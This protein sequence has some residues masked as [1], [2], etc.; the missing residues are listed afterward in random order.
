MN[1]LAQPFRKEKVHDSIIVNMDQ[2]LTSHQKNGNAS[3]WPIVLLDSL[4]LSSVSKYNISSLLTAGRD[5]F[6][7]IAEFNFMPIR[8]RMRGYE[9]DHFG[10]AINGISLDNMDNRIWPYGLYGGLNEVMRNKDISIGLRNN[11]FSFGKLGNMA[12]IDASA[13]KQRKQTQFGYAFS[14][15]NY[16]HKFSYTKGFG[17]NKSGWAFALSGSHRWANEGYIPGTNYNGWS[18]YIAIDKRIKQQHLFSFVFFGALTKNARQGAATVE[19]ISLAGNNYYNPNWGYWQ[20]QKRNANIANA[21]QPV[22]ILTHEFSIHNTS[23]LQTALSYRVGNKSYS[24]LDWFNVT[25]PRP[26]YYKKLPSYNRR[27]SVLYSSLMQQWRNDER[28]RQIDWNTLYSVNNSFNETFNN[29]KGYRS[30]YILSAAV[31]HSS[32]FNFNTTLNTHIND[33]LAFTGGGSLH[34]QNDHYYKKVIDLLGG[35]YFVDLNP[36]AQLAYPN[37]LNAAQSD[38]N[39]PN[40]VLGIGD[41]Y[42]Y[43]YIIHSKKM[44]V[45]TQLF[46]RVHLFDV[47]VATEF[48]PISFRRV[49]NMKNGLFPNHSFGEGETS[50]FYN[51]AVKAGISCKLNGRHYLYLHMAQLTKA[52]SYANVYYAPRIRDTKQA[53]LP[54]EN[55]KLIESGYILNSPRI[56]SRLT[57]YYTQFSHQLAIL[58]FY[59]DGYRSLVNYALSNINKIHYGIELGFDV[60]VKSGLVVDGAASAGSFFYTSRQ[61]ANTILGNDATVLNEDTLYLNG[62]RQGNMPPAVCSIGITYQSPNN[63]FISLTGNYFSSRWLA[64]NPIRH[65]SKAVENLMVGSAEYTAILRQEQLASQFV[66]DLFTSYSWRLPP[67]WTIYRRLTVLVMSAGI[68]N[69]LNNQEIVSGG[70]EQLRFDFITNQS[71]KFPP[72]YYYAFGLNYYITTS[73]RF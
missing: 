2:G 8:F 59:H 33:H 19:A 49:G 53:V 25:D 40:R 30:Y 67:K 47:F 10:I 62:Y 7:S 45:W 42:Q 18:Y 73:L 44:A 71:N 54:N 48:S 4:E 38:L 5:P 72:K 69:L 43:D 17:F 57:A 24:S 28:L 35:D 14:N 58:T 55:I 29:V 27:N 15:R 21:A 31:V 65:S 11:T 46:W 64:V 51:A 3:N 32:V 23:S 68:S 60:K 50:L 9:A 13:S 1:S 34:L 41:K 52:P 39:H 6:L 26:D 70:Y 66:M 37:N 63:W 16:T 20:G 22:C 56:K 12:N 61:N 36:F